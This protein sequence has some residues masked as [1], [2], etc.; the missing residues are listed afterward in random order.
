MKNKTISKLYKVLLENYSIVSLI[1]P[2][3]KVKDNCL[4]L[5]FLS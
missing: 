3:Y 1:I 5:I 2:K 4:L